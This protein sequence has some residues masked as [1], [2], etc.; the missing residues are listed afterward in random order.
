[1]F[2]DSAI[3]IDKTF[4]L[5]IVQ[6]AAQLLASYGISALPLV[7]GISWDATP[8][9]ISTLAQPAADLVIGTPDRAV[10]GN[11]ASTAGGKGSKRSSLKRN[12]LSESKRKLTASMSGAPQPTTPE[13][14]RGCLIID[15][16]ACDIMSKYTYRADLRVGKPITV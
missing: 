4:V 5:Q 7:L 11:S 2:N 15:R 14:T 12:S 6:L 8:E 13:C 16:T 3:I 9:A 1:M 10:G